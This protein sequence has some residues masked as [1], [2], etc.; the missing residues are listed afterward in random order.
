MARPRS[1]PDDDIFRAVRH[2]LGKDGERGVSF[3]TVSKRSGLS[4]PSLAQRYGSRAR[5]IQDALEA[6]W[7]DLARA[8]EAA[9]AEAPPTTKGAAAFLKAIEAGHDDLGRDILVLASGFRDPA[10]RGRAASWQ[11]QVVTG[12][13]MRLGKGG[14]A[15][16]DAGESMFAAWQ[17][18]LFWSAVSDPGFK[19][20][21]VMRRV[22]AAKRK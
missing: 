13:A 14:T 16:M 7:S 10:L 22:V 19:M 2:L 18:Q 12:L 6:G 9:E 1:I 8:T 3:A 20:K 21:R 17:G 5:M 11:R 15:D 4:A